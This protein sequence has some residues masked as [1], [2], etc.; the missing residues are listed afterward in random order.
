MRAYIEIK[1]ARRCG[2]KSYIIRE[3][4]ILDL[5]P[6]IV[7][8]RGISQNEKGWLEKRG[9]RDTVSLRA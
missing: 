7:G 3:V 6:A 2:R 1:I 5:R 9:V 4:L 8:R